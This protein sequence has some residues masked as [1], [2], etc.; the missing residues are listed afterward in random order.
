[1]TMVENEERGA[2][3]TNAR[4]IDIEAPMIWCI[5]QKYILE[6]AKNSDGL[7]YKSIHVSQKNKLVLKAN[8]HLHFLIMKNKNLFHK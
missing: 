8:I 6:R 1:M 3:V 2:A 7:K 4:H 5:L